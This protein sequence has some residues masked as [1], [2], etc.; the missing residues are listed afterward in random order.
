MT[1][2]STS[3]LSLLL[4]SSVLW[5]SWVSFHA[6]AWCPLDAAFPTVYSAAAL[7]DIARGD[8]AASFGPGSDRRMMRPMT[9]LNWRGKLP[10]L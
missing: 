2:R 6:A 4:S 1:R 8:F 10:V 5:I 9:L 3:S 7:I